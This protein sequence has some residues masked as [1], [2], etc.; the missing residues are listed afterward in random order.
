M[1]SRIVGRVLPFPERQIAGTLDDSRT[2]LP[3]VLEVLVDIV[4]GN[5]NVLRHFMPAASLER[6]AFSAK[7]RLRAREPEAFGV[8]KGSSKKVNRHLH[9]VI[10]RYGNDGS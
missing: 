3:S 2:E 1:T 5:V 9:V 7:G 4:H 10:N 6:S 8:G